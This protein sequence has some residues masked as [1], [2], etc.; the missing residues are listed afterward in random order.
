MRCGLVMNCPTVI[1]KGRRR[2]AYAVTEQRKFPPA[3]RRTKPGQLQRGERSECLR[4]GRPAERARPGVSCPSASAASN[5]FQLGAQRRPPVGRALADAGAEEL[6]KHVLGAAHDAG[7]RRE[8]AVRAGRQRRGDAPGTAPTGR[9]SSRAIRAVI[10]APERCPA[11]TTTV[12][13]RQRGDEPVAGREHPAPHRVPRR[14]LGYAAPLAL[15]WRCSARWPADTDGRR[16]RGAQ[17]RRAAAAASA[18]AWAAE[19]MPSAMPLI[20]GT[21]AAPSPRPSERATS[22]P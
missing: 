9:P 17:R 6:V 7:A 20:T 10:S 2:A 19:S 15:I 4:S 16:R 21:P 12:I 5:R 18:P 1:S 22:R 14:Q 3:P 13:A 8:Q 11:S